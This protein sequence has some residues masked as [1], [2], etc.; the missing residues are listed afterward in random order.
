MMKNNYKFTLSLLIRIF[1]F[2]I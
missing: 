2:Q 1:L